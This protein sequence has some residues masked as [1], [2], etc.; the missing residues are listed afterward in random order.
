MGTTWR[1]LPGQLNQRQE[2]KFDGGLNKGFSPFDIGS[3]Q[4][5]SEK[6]LDT[7]NF[8]ALT[9]FKRPSVYGATGSVQTNLLTNFKN[10]HLVRAVGTAL[11]YDNSGT[12]TAIAGTFTNTDWDSTNFND[13]LIITNGTDNV[14][15][16]NGS[17]LSDL[18]VNA[19]KGKYIASDDL[20]V[21]IAKDD[22]IYYSAFLDETDWLTAENSGIVQYYTPRGGNITALVSFLDDIV[23]FKKDSMGQI[24]GD[25]YYDYTLVN[26]SND[27]GCVS[28]K[29]V[30]EVGDTLFWLGQN[31]VYAYR[32]GKPSPIGQPI[33]DYLDDINTAQ[34]SKCFGGTDGIKYY[35]GLVTGANTEPNVL[36]IYDPRYQIWRVAS[37]DD[38]YRYSAVLNNVWYVGNSTGQTYKMRQTYTGSTFE[39]VSK[40][41]D[42]GI[43]EAEKEYYE[44][45][46]Q[47]YLPAGSTMTIYVSTRDRDLDDGSD[48]VEIDTI[49]AS[50]L[51]QS[52]DIIIPLDTVPLAKWFRYKISGTG[53]VEIYQVQRYFRIQPTQH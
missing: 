38:N 10:T 40:P 37:L 7:D 33:R 18:S 39:I 14:K 49:T 15:Q 16:W 42:E 53:E 30:Q 22:A 8:P 47:G 6:G 24:M 44:M 52:E 23:I 35:L 50:T 34:L 21:W 3:N 11:Q 46:I 31:D 28:F 20:R 9:S 36:L 17:V 45:H 1:T 26:V 41:F 51:A 19:P 12:W 25:N 43:P 48:W 4:S 27:I 2:N 29:T 32:G 13:K 5:V